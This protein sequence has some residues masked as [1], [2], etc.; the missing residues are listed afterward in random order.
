MIQYCQRCGHTSESESGVKYCPYCGSPFEATS[1]TAPVVSLGESGNTGQSQTPPS[2][3]PPI[4]YVPWEDKKSLGFLG[5]LFETWKESCFNPQK[6]FEKMSVKGG[7]GNPLLYALIIGFIG[8]IFQ[9]TYSQIFNQMFDFAKWLPSMSS[10]FD[11][12]FVEFNQ[13]IQSYSNII[14]LFI[15]PFAATAGF[16]IWSGIIHLLLS[17]FGWEKHDYEASF[18]IVTYSEGP[19]F[20]RIIPIIGDIIAPIWQIVL[21]IIGISKVHKTSIGNAI[22]VVIL[23]TLIVCACCCFSL[24]WLIGFLGMT[25]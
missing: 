5:A 24:F 19:A 23:P 10:S 8:T 9:V 22:L 21:T 14:S 16:F 3:Q 6:F 12:D 25:R 15:F 20:F 11:Y 17:I 1:E 18:R 2:E 13:R 4:Y 7:I